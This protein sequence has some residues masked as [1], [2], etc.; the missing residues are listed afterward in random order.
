MAALSPSH[1]E[2][3]ARLNR[4]R[5][6]AFR[7]NVYEPVAQG[8][9][10]GIVVGGGGPG[11]G[12][13]IEG[14]SVEQILNDQ[15]DT[16]AVRTGG[17]TANAGQTIAIYSGDAIAAH[18]IFGGRIIATTQ[19]YEGRKQNIAKDLR[20]VD[21]T[22]LLN[23]R[24][25]L[26]SFP[27]PTYASDII[28]MLVAGWGVGAIGA[29][30]YIT[31]PRTQAYI[32][33]QITFTNEYLPVCL[34]AV[35]ERVGAHWYVDYANNLHAF[36]DESP[37]ANSITDATPHGAADLALT[38]D[39]SQVVTK[40][41]GRG[42][43]ASAAV[44]TPV[45]ATELPVDEGVDATIYSLSGGLVE[46]GAQVLTYAGMRGRGG[47]GAFIG[48]GNAP[49][50]APRPEPLGG[51]SHT[52]GATYKYAASFTT[53][54]G[55]TLPGPV[56][57][58]TISNIPLAAPIPP[59]ARTRGGGTYPPGALSPGGTSMRFALQ[60]S[61]VGGAFGPMSAPSPSYTWDGNDWEIY[62]GARTDLAGG[63][64]WYPAIESSFVAPVASIMVHRSDN[65][66]AWMP[67]VNFLPSSYLGSAPGWW[68]GNCQGYTGGA[69]PASSGFG[70]VVVR[71]IPVGAA[72]GITGRKLYR[73]VANGSALKLLTTVT[74][75]VDTSFADG[76]ADAALG[77]APPVGDTS[78]IKD[79]GQVLPGAASLPVSSTQPFADD[80]GPGG[81]G[82]WARVGTM[83]VRYTG[84]GA[85]VLTGI[86]AS[87]NGSIT[88]ATRYGT[89]VLVQPRLIGIP[90]SGT[91]SITLAILR[92]DTVTI[93]IEKTDAAARDVMA[94]RLVPFTGAAVNPDYGII[95]LVVSDSRFGLVELQDHIDAT[96]QDRKDPQLTITFTS[97]DLTLQVGRLITVNTT[98]PPISGTFRIHK[99][100]LSQIA[101]S[102][103]RATVHPLKTVEASSKI[104]KFTDLLRRLRSM[105]AG[106]R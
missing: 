5:L 101:E 13:R 44:D 85:G 47:L 57:S 29:A 52:V 65:G 53:A 26:A 17:I 72:S 21:P 6:K 89:Q 14:A 71:A 28:G 38:E 88:A 54:T 20:C 33:D 67:A 68:G 43:G 104:Y 69:I 98:Q 22:W 40:V 49:S 105:E 64:F 1:R 73:T 27:L 11:T 15:T 12:F 92:G 62:I 18:Q 99:I 48:T 82:G 94:A 93:R 46:T 24:T 55:E 61:Y 91:G 31:I 102:G 39:L 103:G 84:I 25:V 32:V 37:D 74:N 87:G 83:P 96:L 81:T 77:A 30:A 23:R 10:G 59:T 2:G 7:L 8:A 9:I 76:I 106:V 97:R 41:I 34:T 60:I 90:P 100:A 86:P 58:I 51:S 3:C 4:A 66:G 45:G 56:G 75:N 70:S 80:V 19:L 36:I 50:G 63:G 35:C 42:G 95:E 16:A 78:A 79:E